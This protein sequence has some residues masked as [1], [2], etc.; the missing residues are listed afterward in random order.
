MANDN[1]PRMGQSAR[2]RQS[3]VEEKVGSKIS[4]ASILPPTPAK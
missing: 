2:S 3:E 4:I 1:W